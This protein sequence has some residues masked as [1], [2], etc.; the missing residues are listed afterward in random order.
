MTFVR[1]ITRG[2]RGLGNSVTDFLYNAAT[3]NLSEDQVGKAVSSCAVDN[4][5]AGGGRITMAEAQAQCESDIRAVNKLN[6]ADADHSN[7]GKALLFGGLCLGALFVIV[8]R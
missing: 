3:G 2:R 5:R 6:I 7:M 1:Q 8:R 4:Y